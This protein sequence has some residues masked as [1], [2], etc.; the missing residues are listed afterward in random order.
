MKKKHLFWLLL[1]SYWVLT[2]VAI[3]A[4]AGVS[5]FLALG[6]ALVATIAIG[7]Q[8]HRKQIEHGA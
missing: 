5:G 2:A 3:V 7:V 6:I 4:A 8:E 1:P